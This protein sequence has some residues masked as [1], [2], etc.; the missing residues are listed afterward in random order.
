M[1]NAPSF[2]KDAELMVKD[3]LKIQNYALTIKEHKLSVINLQDTFQIQLID[4]N[5]II[6]LQL[7][8]LLIVSS[9]HVIWQLD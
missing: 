3:A 6:Q 1:K 5:A 8:I 2:K 7:Q 9:K 4:H